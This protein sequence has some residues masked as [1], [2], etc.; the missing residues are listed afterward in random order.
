MAIID[1]ITSAAGGG[2]F[3]LIG[4]GFNRIAGYFERK[5]LHEFE[6]KKMAHVERQNEHVKD[7]RLMEFDHETKLHELTM[8]AGRARALEDMAVIDTQGSWDGLTASIEAEA[9]IGKASQWVINLLRLVRPIITLSLWLIV[10][11]IYK[12]T[13][14]AEIVEAATFAATAATLW[15]FGDRWRNP[16]RSM[17]KAPK[18][19][20]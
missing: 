18:G 15:W 2:L 7:L 20:A 14:D 11:K 19:L 17:G 4:T 13:P 10:W 8:Q 16:L 9:A 1:F 6:L 12:N 3:G 5:Q